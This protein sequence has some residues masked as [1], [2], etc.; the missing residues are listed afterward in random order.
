MMPRMQKMYFA[1]AAPLAAPEAPE[2][3]ALRFYRITM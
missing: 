1:N 3:R 2:A